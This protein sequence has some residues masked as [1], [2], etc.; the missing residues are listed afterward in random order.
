[1][2]NPGVVASS[3]SK[4]R[5]IKRKAL[6]I[7]CASAAIAA[8]VVAPQKARAQAFDG[9]V[10][11]SLNATR[12]NFGTGTE[13]VTVTGQKAVINWAP[14]ES[15]T[16]PTIEFLPGGNVATFQGGAGITDYT[17]LNRVVPDGSRAISLNGTVLSKV[18]GGAT[19]GK[20]W[21]YSPNGIV[22]GP[23]AVFDV[24]G[25][26]LTTADIPDTTDDGFSDFTADANGFSM[27]GVVT[28]PNSA[29]DIQSD[30]I[31]SAN[32]T[33]NNYVAMIAP[34]I[35]QG[36]TVTVNGSAAYVAAEALTM[37]MNQGL[38]NIQ[39]DIGGD[40]C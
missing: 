18:D 35:E 10:S 16:A 37:T 15:G 32:I 9:T 19:G 22:V 29:I 4:S 3:V 33:A 28:N 30:E 2:T 26:L 8:G 6:L 39:V 24:G 27:R 40:D 1:M 17:V 38:F 5:S 7:S 34:R 31:S 36:G 20:V 13:T 11:S 12:G 25:L 14:D 23:N 21:F